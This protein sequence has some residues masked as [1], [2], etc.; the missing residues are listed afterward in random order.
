MLGALGALPPGAHVLSDGRLGVVVG[1]GKT[2]LTPLVLLAG[3]INAPDAPVTP[4]SPLGM[5]PWAK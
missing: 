2:P 5:T 3:E 1:P 4:H